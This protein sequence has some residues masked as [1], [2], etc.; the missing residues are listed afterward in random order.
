MN[1]AEEVQ[2]RIEAYLTEIDQVI[3]HAKPGAGLFGI[4]ISPKN[5][6]CNDRFLTGMQTWFEQFALS[7]PSSEETERVMDIVFTAQQRRQDFVFFTLIAIHGM[8]I[9]LVRF[10]TPEAAGRQAEA[11]ESRIPKTQRMP[12]QLKL[13]D[14]L[15]RRAGRQPRK[16]GLFGRR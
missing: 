10:L 3:A 9:P 14:E 13:L 1:A 12:V 15:Y 4:G 16:R 7:E 6:P 2:E 11:Y 5:D 8:A